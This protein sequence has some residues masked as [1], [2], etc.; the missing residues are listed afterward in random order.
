MTE[1]TVGPADAAT[2]RADREAL[3][4]LWIA[5]TDAGGAVGFRP[6]ADAV[7][8]GEV[9]DGLLATVDRGGAQAVVA[10]DAGGAPV[11]LVVVHPGDGPRVAHRVTLRRLMVHP[12]RQ[13]TGTGARL[14]SAAHDLAVRAFGAELAVVE[15][16]G[17]LGLEPFY[18]GLG[19]TEVGRIPDGL[20]FDDGDRVDEVL[21]AR[22][23]P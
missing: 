10:R 7:A 6:P 18:L 4:A 22:R 20:A 2:L 12:D 14:V 11:G 19:Y 1:I 13:R 16:R 9:L 8:V 21:L 5:V 3:L 15:V 17:S 23:L